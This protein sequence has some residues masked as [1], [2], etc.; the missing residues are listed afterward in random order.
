MTD[1]DHSFAAELDGDRYRLSS[2]GWSIVVGP[3]HLQHGRGDAFADVVGPA[4]ERVRQAVE[5]ILGTE[6]S[7]LV[8]LG[9]PPPFRCR[10]CQ[11]TLPWPAP[12]RIHC[13]ACLYGPCTMKVCRLAA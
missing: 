3:R 8:L 7:P 1:R 12:G 2:S 5:A 4:V 6:P 11:R 9:E 13:D 10:C